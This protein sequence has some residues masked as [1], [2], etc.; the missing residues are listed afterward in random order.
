MKLKKL[1]LEN[2]RGFNKAEIDFDDNMNVIIGKNDIGKSTILE[3]LELFINGENKDCQIKIDSA[4]CNISAVD[5]KITIGA[6]FKIREDEPIVI[7]STNPTKLSEEYLLNSDGLLEIHRVYDC[8]KQKINRTDIK[9]YIKAAYPSTF[10]KPLV[11][12]KITEL[13]KKLDELKDNIDDYNSV[14]KTKSAEIRKAIYKVSN[15]EDKVVTYIDINSSD[16]T[17]NVW[18]SIKKNLPLYFL[19]QS[20]RPNTDGDSEVQNPLKIATKNAL[21]KVQEYLDKV[22][23]EVEKEVMK[24]GQET[25]EKLKDFNTDIAT[26]LKTNL[27]LKGWDSVFSFSLIGDDNIPL[28]KRGS[29]VRRLILLSYFRAEAERIIKESSTNEVIYAIEEPET[30]QHPDYQKM[31][32]Q[33]L[34]EISNDEKHQII[35]TTHTPEIAKMVS[36]EQLIFIRRNDKNEPTIEKDENAKIKGIVDTLGV[37][38]TAI[39]KLVICVEGEND[40]NFLLNINQSIEEFK[41]IIDLKKEK[42]SI[43]PM[44]GSNLIT[45]VNKDYLKDSNVIEFH[46]YDNDKK[47]Y[48]ELIKNIC[49]ANDGRRYGFNTK[50]LEMENY[51]H[52]SLIKEEFG[53][54]FSEDLYAWGSVDVPQFLKDK[55]KPEIADASEREKCIKQILNCRVAKKIT[56][57]HLREIGVFDEV[58]G[59]F[60]E[61]KRLYEA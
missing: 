19:F 53:I 40:V 46:L 51:I 11:T 22:K 39:S 2:F 24:I 52:P 45:W 29:G 30:S 20:D 56:K 59:W 28:N 5:K 42:I 26:N 36:R 25:I 14:D 55:V 47:E 43:I 9:T 33:T 35:I 50:M 48:C 7:D 61:I 23:S 31:L 3:A 34:L 16:D 54:E 1:I 57:E 12:M 15:I 41:N 58:E 6:C 18:E 60:R 32:I 38:P 37:L 44:Q 17:K 21:T 13:R 8:S 10:E 49:A 4:D 27:D